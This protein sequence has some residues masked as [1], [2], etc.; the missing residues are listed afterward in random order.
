MTII[1]ALSV[2]SQLVN[3]LFLRLW[4]FLS[5]KFTNKSVLAISGPLFILTI[6]CWPFTTMPERYVLTIPLLI[7]IHVLAGMSTAGVVIG[8]GNIAIKIAPKGKATSFLAVNA[9]V[10]GLSATA[11]PLLGGVAGAMLES[12][13]LSLAL[14]WMT[15]DAVHWTIPAIE[16]EGLDFLFILAVIF[17]IY[18]LH[19]LSAVVEAGDVEKGIVLNQFHQEIRKAVRSVSN[20]A[21]IRDLFYFPYARIRQ[22]PEIKK[23]KANNDL[24]G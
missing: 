8:T 16:L 17:G 5:D 11:A 20:V 24:P 18:S 15:G 12:K 14:S 22:H 19:R 9:F 1:L 7:F 21:G 2:L 23:K 4:G 3:I 6:A 10:S 13:R